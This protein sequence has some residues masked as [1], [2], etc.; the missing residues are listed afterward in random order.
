[1]KTHCLIKVIHTTWLICETYISQKVFKFSLQKLDNISRK[2]LNIF[3][4]VELDEKIDHVILKSLKCD[5]KFKDGL[6]NFTL[7]KDL[8]NS[9]IN[10]KVLDA[11]IIHSLDYYRKICR[12]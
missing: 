1:M 3:P 2:I 12:R 11:D 4:S 9:V 7:I 6:Y 5:K 8:G 10:C